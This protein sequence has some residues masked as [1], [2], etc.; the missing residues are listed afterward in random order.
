MLTMMQMNR[1]DYRQAARREVPT[2]RSPYRNALEASLR[3]DECFLCGLYCGEYR[4]FWSDLGIITHTI[5][6]D[7]HD[8]SCRDIIHALS[9]GGLN[10]RKYKTKRQVLELAWALRQQTGRLPGH[11]AL[12]YDGP[13]YRAQKAAKAGRRSA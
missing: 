1:D 6:V 4:S 10:G 3:W 5:P 9:L 11:S 12:Y 2:W 13:T 8:T 7:G